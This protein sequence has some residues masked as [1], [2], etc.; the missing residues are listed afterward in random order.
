MEHRKLDMTW[1]KSARTVQRQ[2]VKDVQNVFLEHDNLNAKRL[3]LIQ[4]EQHKY[5]GNGNVATFY[6]MEMGMRVTVTY[7]VPQSGYVLPILQM[8][9]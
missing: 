2:Y 3:V 4:R 7:V 6:R 9:K 8:R 1:I 5:N